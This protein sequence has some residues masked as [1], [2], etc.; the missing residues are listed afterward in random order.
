MVIAKSINLNS[1]DQLTH[2]KT[3]ASDRIW[4]IKFDNENYLI[5]LDSGVLSWKAQYTI[6]KFFFLP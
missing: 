5:E 1:K 3:I 4:S 6:S 2:I